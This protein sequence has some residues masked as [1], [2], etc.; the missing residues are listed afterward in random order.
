VP[1][2]ITT[3]ASATKQTSA[4]GGATGRFS[5]EVAAFE[6][7][8]R[9]DRLVTDLTRLGY[10]ARSVTVVFDPPRPP[11]VQVLVGRYSSTVDAEED[12]TTIRELFADARLERMGR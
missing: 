9:A 6:T 12:L 8:E 4:A 10:A 11:L 3:L 7:S 1:D 5:I 2:G